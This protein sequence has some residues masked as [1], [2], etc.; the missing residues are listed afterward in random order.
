M[1]SDIS[2]DGVWK[3]GKLMVVHLEERIPYG[4]CAFRNPAI[5]ILRPGDKEE[6]IH[7]AFDG[8]T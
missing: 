4:D 2:S 1:P 5:L 3:L 7:R 8:F 6:L